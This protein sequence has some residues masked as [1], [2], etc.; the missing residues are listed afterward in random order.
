MA[1]E[2]REI[3]LKL[4][5]QSLQIEKNPTLAKNVGTSDLRDPVSGI[6]RIY[7]RRTVKTHGV[8]PK[9]IQCAQSIQNS[10]MPAN[11]A[12]FCRSLA[13]NRN[14]FLSIGLNVQTLQFRKW[15]N[16]FVIV[17]WQRIKPSH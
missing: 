4:R 2:E 17:I 8:I 16:S 11:M 15:S 10:H 12:N 13:F 5:V 7:F 14:G 1:S 3:L 6:G 9:R